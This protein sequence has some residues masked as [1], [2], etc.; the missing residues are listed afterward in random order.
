MA[1]HP[2]RG[3]L[4]CFKKSNDSPLN[5]SR[6]VG[7]ISLVLSEEPTI[8]MVWTCSENGRG[9]TPKTGYRSDFTASHLQRGT[10]KCFKKSYDSTLNFS[11][12]VGDISL[13]LS[14]EPTIEMVWT[15]SENGRGKSPK[16]GYRSDFTAS[17]PQ[18]GALTCF[19]KSYN[20]PLNFSRQVGD[21]SL[22]LSEDLKNQQLKC[23]GHVQRM[24][25][26]ILPKQV[27][28]WSPPGRR[29]RGRPKLSWVEGIRGLMGEKGLVE[30]DWNDRDECRKKIL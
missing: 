9:K 26:G 6:Q 27:M 4:K 15:C 7:D 16:T 1:S 20:S 10:L 21:I 13:V 3:A 12:Q 25:E 29:K 22:V 2:Q 19:K 23:Y 30:E 14:E 18:R 28:K 8:E 24:E 17:H 11:R 5:F